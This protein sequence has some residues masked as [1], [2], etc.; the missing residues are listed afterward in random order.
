[1]HLPCRKPG[2]RRSSKFRPA[3]LSAESLKLRRLERPPVNIAAGSERLFSGKTEM[4][5]HSD[6]DL[7]RPKFSTPPSKTAWTRTGWGTKGHAKPH[8]H[9]Y[10]GVGA[11][12][13][14]ERGGAIHPDYNENGECPG[15]PIANCNLTTETGD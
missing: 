13:A 10:R 2:L 1:M 15:L 6:S 11:A 8:S 7:K 5:K 14:D 9:T 3:Q 12:T 4:E